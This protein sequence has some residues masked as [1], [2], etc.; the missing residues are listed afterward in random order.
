MYYV[1]MGPGFVLFFKF[2]TARLADVDKIL[3]A[4]KSLGHVSGMF[5]YLLLSR[6]ERLLFTPC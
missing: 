3:M 5:P 2:Y 4:C 1:F 6:P